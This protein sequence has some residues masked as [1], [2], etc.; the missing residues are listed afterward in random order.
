MTHFEGEWATAR[1]G[2]RPI[3]PPSIFPGLPKSCLKQVQTKQ[4]PTRCGSTEMRRKSEE[5]MNDQRDKITNL[6]DFIREIKRCF[7]LFYF[8]NDG[9]ELTMFRTD[10]T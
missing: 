8:V 9:E 2:R 6:K 10:I 5:A 1:G 3:I 4:R 7:P